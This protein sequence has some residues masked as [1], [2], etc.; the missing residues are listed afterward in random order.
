MRGH[1]TK[2]SKGTWSLVLDMGRDPT[3]GKRRQ[4]W[5]SVK[6][7]KAD[8]QRKLTELLHQVDTGLSIPKG[9]LTVRDWLAQWLVQDIK[10][11]K[12]I[13]THDRYTGVVQKHLNPHI[14]HIRLAA[15]APTH[16]K[17]LLALLIGHG[18]VPAGVDLCRTVLHG[19]LKAAIQQELLSRNVVDATTPPRVERSEIVPP[20][21]KSVVGMLAQAAET[22]HPLF[23]ALHLLAYTGARRG[24]I[25]GLDWEHVN[26]TSGT[27]SIVRS[28][29][30]SREGL[31]FGP[32]KTSNG[33]RVIDLDQRTVEVLQAHQGSQLLEKIQAEGA[34]ADNGL[35]FANALG[36]PINPMQVTRAF[37]T[38]ARKY[39]AGH[40]KLHAL[41]HFHASVL[42]QQKQSLFAVSRR[43]GHASISTT[44]DLYGHMLPGSGKEQANAFAE[45]MLYR[46]VDAE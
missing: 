44:A 10:P 26:M 33:R 25:L 30:R 22:E 35:V 15:L 13:K 4:Q 11:Y 27:I 29:G 41:R 31:T 19:A 7:T 8:A 39:G 46:P 38:L 37:Q 1:I 36:A 6:G 5:V 45:A 34:Y 14:G 42:F 43:L 17:D 3:T 21:I 20:V 32:P 24:E 9:K 40:V 18:M 28:L 2:R 12:A 16:V 23:A